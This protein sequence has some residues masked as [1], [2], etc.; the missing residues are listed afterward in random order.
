MGRIGTLRK[1]VPDPIRRS[2]LLKFAVVMIVVLAVTIGA[3][4]FVQQTVA[5]DLQDEI[6]AEMEMT[7]DL[8]ADKME[9]WFADRK[10]NVK[11]ISSNERIAAEDE[12]EVE[13][14]LQTSLERSPDDVVAVHLVDYSTDQ[15][16]AS[17]EDGAT[18]MA[19]SGRIPR[20]WV[21]GDRPSELA[22]GEATM[23]EDFLIDGG[24]RIGFISPVSVTDDTHLSGGHM[25]ITEVDAAA[26]AESFQ[27][28]NEAVHV[29]VTD[30]RG[31]MEFAVDEEREYGL[32]ADGDPLTRAL[33]GEVH[34]FED[35]EM[36]V[37]LAPVEGTDWVVVTSAERSAVYGVH[38][39]VVNSLFVL[40][41]VF[42]LGF[43][44]LGIG[45]G[46]DV[47]GSLDDLTTKA[48]RLENGD[49]E[50]E[51][52]STRVDEFGRLY[53]AF[54]SMRTSLQQQIDEAERAK[55]Q[56][57]DAKQESERFSEHLE[58]KAEAYTE[59]MEAAASGD[60]TSEMNPESESEAMAE[61]GETYNEMMAELRGIIGRVQVF[62]EDLE[63]TV[64]D[65]VVGVED[66][67]EASD[68]VSRSVQSISAGTDDQTQR[69]QTAA[70][71][72]SE[73]SATV[74]E[75][76]AS[77]DNVAEKSQRAAE[78]G[79]EGRKQADEALEAVAEI[80]GRMDDGIEQ[81]E[82]LE[83]QIAEIEE[84]VDVIETIAKETNMLALNASIEAANADGSGDGFAVVADEVKALA[85]KTAESTAEI[86][87]RIERVET[88]TDAT[89]EL[90]HEAGSEVENGTETIAQAVRSLEEIV[91]LVEDADEGMQSINDAT[92]EQA[93]STEDI[94]AS[95]EGVKDICAETS[96]EAASVASAAEEQTAIVDEVSEELRSTAEDAADLRELTG[97]F[98]VGE[99]ATGAHTDSSPGMGSD[100]GAADG[101]RP[102]STDGGSE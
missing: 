76:A 82:S 98:E 7:A 64:D 46:R 10:S 40:I 57:R 80:E 1:A 101:S 24:E 52:G 65:V 77:S 2:Y 70:N 31:V 59:T 68:D 16:V 63:R 19:L 90:M 27:T 48:E 55:T 54:D 58:A 22:D 38:S 85:E 44:A 61:I 11:V 43:V 75:I 36:V 100:T 69:V 81:V 28:R 56:A 72:L 87:D 20:W 14:A 50:T 96:D 42:A 84:I 47:V 71:E 37:G 34:S 67:E 45:V 21:E 4:V 73:L 9:A 33:A 23:S 17:T 79:E 51:I 41:G 13:A 5:D 62:A 25:V 92:D 99:E 74:E 30:S 89:V 91:E 15:I 18:E 39:S 8:E 29:Q 12:A 97:A 95:I 6:H 94:V 60:L 88:T 3:G 32:Q 53:G 83:A 102:V 86:A 93:R 78:R 26:R 49:L 35:D 66:V